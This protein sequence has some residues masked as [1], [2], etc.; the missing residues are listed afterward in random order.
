MCQARISSEQPTATVNAS[1]ER[2]ATAGRRRRGATSTAHS[3]SASRGGRVPARP[4]GGAD[5]RE[6]DLHVRMREQRLEHLGAERRERQHAA[7]ASATRGRPRAIANS[8]SARPQSVKSSGF[9]QPEQRLADGADVLAVEPR[10]VAQRRGV[11]DLD[12]VARARRRPT[13]ARAPTR[14]SAASDS[15]GERAGAPRAR[16]GAG[17]GQAC[18]VYACPDIATGYEAALKRR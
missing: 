8:T 18:A 9:E 7:T 17:A 15:A 5:V 4:G 11:A 2:A 13:S 1:A 12:G 14:H 16:L 10:E 3:A 6:A